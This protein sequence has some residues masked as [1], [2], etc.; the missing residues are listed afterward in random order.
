MRIKTITTEPLE[1]Y[2]EIIVN[3]DDEQETHVVSQIP[4]DLPLHV[5]L[6]ALTTIHDALSQ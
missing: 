3:W 6:E 4:Q 2:R 5:A 1:D